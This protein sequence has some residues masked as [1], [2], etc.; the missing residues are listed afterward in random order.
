[1]IINVDRKPSLSL[2]YIGGCVLRVLKQEN[3]Q[4]IE[5]ILFEIRKSYI[6]DVSI[7]FLYYTLDWL[8]LSNLIKLE[9]ERVCLC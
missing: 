7:N 2:I 1:M 3:K 5:K 4:S 8:F 9:E 6:P